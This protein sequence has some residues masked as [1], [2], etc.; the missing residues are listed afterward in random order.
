MSDV[1]IVGMGAVF[2]GAGDAPAF[3]RN[4]QAGTDAITEV[5]PD[6][7][8]PSVYC[9]PEAG[10]DRFYTSRGGFLGEEAE[11]DPAPFGIMPASVDGTEPDQLLMLRAAAE[12]L[13]DHGSLP[14]DRERV[15]VIIGRGGYL[16]AAF[17]RLDTRVRTV[18]QL[19]A[20]LE[21]LVPGL[22]PERLAAIREAFTDRLAA[23]SGGSG[24]GTGSSGTDAIGLVP[25]FAA[26]RLA[27]RFDLR[28]PAYTVDAACASSLVAVDHAVRELATGRCDAVLAGG[29]HTCHHPTLW[30]VFTRLR[31]IS[32]G[33]VIRPLSAS[34]DGT[35]LS[36][37]TCAVLLKRLADARAAGD[38]IY[39]VI[40]G[41]GISSDGRATSMM[42]PR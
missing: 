33:G 35:L 10:P 4:I 18:H 5:P 23:D 27:N 26:S 2:P 14:G 12:A 38:R 32:P 42:N 29:V 9:G 24:R 22:A 17:S 20:V 15:G 34:A 1:A 3:W 41:V 7:W 21:D 39:A 16:T 31:A 36:E 11:F 30:S 6:R 8:D 40:R 19:T 13:D 28:G 37:G 25:N